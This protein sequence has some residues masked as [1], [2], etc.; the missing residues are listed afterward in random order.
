VARAARRADSRGTVPR[1]NADSEGAG[2]TSARL[3]VAGTTPAVS[4]ADGRTSLEIASIVDH[5]VVVLE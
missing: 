3:L 2:N 1:D 5:E 4:V